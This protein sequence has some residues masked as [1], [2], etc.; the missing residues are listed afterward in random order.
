MKQRNNSIAVAIGSRC[1]SVCCNR[2]LAIRD[3]ARKC[4]RRR[5]VITRRSQVLVPPTRQQVSTK[6]SLPTPE[7]A[8]ILHSRTTRIDPLLLGCSAFPASTEIYDSPAF[9][10]GYS[11]RVTQ[12]LPSPC[13]FNVRVRSASIGLRMTRA[14]PWLCRPKRRQ[15]RWLLP[16]IKGE[17]VGAWPSWPS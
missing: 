15:R 4:G 5:R 9:P 12:Q 13:T 6:H 3:G 7:A 2:P 11:G 1:A 8:V 14:K 10:R 16:N 17:C